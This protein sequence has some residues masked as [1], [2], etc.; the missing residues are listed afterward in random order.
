MYSGAVYVEPSTFD[1]RNVGYNKQTDPDSSFKPN[2]IY[3][4]GNDCRE[5]FDR[6]INDFVTVNAYIY[7]ATSADEIR[8]EFWVHDDFIE[9]DAAVREVFKYGY[10]FGRLPAFLRIGVKAIVIVNGTIADEEETFIDEVDSFGSYSQNILIHTGIGE[11]YLAEGILEEALTYEAIH[12]TIDP[13]ISR[14]E[15][16]VDAILRD[17]NRYVTEYAATNPLREDVAETILLWLA[18]RFRTDRLSTFDYDY[19]VNTIPNRLDF[20][21]N[22]R[23]DVYPLTEPNQ[24]QPRKRDYKYTDL[25]WHTDAS[26]T[27]FC[28]QYCGNMMCTYEVG[29]VPRPEPIVRLGVCISPEMETITKHKGTIKMKDI[30]IGDKVLTSS[31]EYKTIYTIDHYHHNETTHYVQIETSTIA[32]ANDDENS[33]NN[34]HKTM[35]D[36]NEEENDDEGFFSPFVELTPNHL[37]FIENVSYP[38]QAKNVVI[39]DYLRTIH[40]PKEVIHT[41]RITRDG[42]Y[43]PLTT[44]GTIVINGVLAS[45]YTSFLSQKEESKSS[46][47]FAINLVTTTANNGNKNNNDN[48]NGAQNTT[49]STTPTTKKITSDTKTTTTTTTTNIISIHDL[50]HMT[51]IPWRIF[52]MATLS[53]SLTLLDQQ[54]PPEKEGTHPIIISIM[55]QIYDHTYSHFSKQEENKVHAMILYFLLSVYILFFGTISLLV[56]IMEHPILPPLLFMMMSMCVAYRFNI[57]HKMAGIKTKSK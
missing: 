40:G 16:Y 1:D 20:L 36:G 25:E 11:Q 10:A 4:V 43:N 15:W 31:G 26:N 23:Y 30:A 57:F 33:N 19:I 50:I 28:T 39:G 34:N 55:F 29:P 18:V 2:E 56:S 53:S 44:D 9:Q 22:Q 49:T 35:I 42:Y 14:T 7:F 37:L 38:I 48:H 17:N 51:S 52:C 27:D 46:S 32:A 41:K 45:T 47:H 21:N 24:S 12:V 5:I 54:E 6:R 8:T 13:Y 3:F